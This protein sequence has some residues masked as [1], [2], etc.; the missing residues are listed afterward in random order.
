M[1]MKLYLVILLTL[2]STLV[3]L[4]IVGRNKAKVVESKYANDS[5]EE[6]GNANTENNDTLFEIFEKSDPG[7]LITML[8]MSKNAD[9]T[10]NVD[11]VNVNRCIKLGSI[12]KPISNIMDFTLLN[13]KLPVNI[14]NANH[15]LTNF[16]I[17]L[18]SEQIIPS[19]NPSKYVQCMGVRDTGSEERRCDADFSGKKAGKKTSGK[20]KLEIRDHMGKCKC[21]Y[22]KNSN[23]CKSR[24]EVV[25]CGA[26]CTEK[27]KE[28]G[29]ITWCS[30]K[31]LKKAIQSPSKTGVPCA[32][33]PKNMDEFI[34]ATIAWNKANFDVAHRENE[35]DAYI[36]E[37]DENQQVIIDSIE[38]FVF[39]DYCGSQRCDAAVSKALQKQ[40]ERATNDFNK[41]YSKSVP[42]YKLLVN[43]N[44]NVGAYRNGEIVTWED[45][46]YTSDLKSLMVKIDLDPSDVTKPVSMYTYRVS[47]NID[48]IAGKN[49]GDIKGDNSYISGEFCPK[50]GDDRCLNSI[51]T[52][53]KVDYLPLNPIIPAV[54]SDQNVLERGFGNYA[55]CNPGGTVGGS[56]RY[57]CTKCSDSSIKNKNAC[58]YGPGIEIDRFS[59]GK[60]YSWPAKTMC[61]NFDDIGENGCNWK[62]DSTNVK[63]FSMK[64]LNKNNNYTL[65]TSEKYKQ[66]LN[67][68]GCNPSAATFKSCKEKAIKDFVIKHANSNV[69]ALNKAFDVEP[70]DHSANKKYDINTTA[71]ENA[72]GVGVVQSTLR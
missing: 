58:N 71:A 62:V 4:E 65:M 12:S 31:D 44:V 36:E 10:P 39:T 9:G 49:T 25:G 14:Y 40:M 72:I 43:P 42:L 33:H 26:K 2:L 3:V 53:Y 54:D 8:T 32:I 20:Y 7:L 46:D 35:L 48:G 23:T 69:K 28:C 11:S 21:K 27:G 29:K 63:H 38:C 57:R 19:E 17:I 56:G 59:G 16:G 41:M 18:N 24:A 70:E 45:N 13:K 15:Y 22:T 55:L 5:S 68:F 37:T 61:G 67:D 64:E 66:A 6:G 30:S 50:Y 51:V 60:W 1:I 34:Q 47:A 52:Q